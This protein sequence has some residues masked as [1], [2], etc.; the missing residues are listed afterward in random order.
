MM[1]R[2][3]APLLQLLWWKKFPYFLRSFRLTLFS[4][5]FKLLFNDVIDYFLFFYRTWKRTQ[6]QPNQGRLSPC[7]H[8]IKGFSQASQEALK[9]VDCGV[10]LAFSASLSFFNEGVINPMNKKNCRTRCVFYYIYLKVT[11]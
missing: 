7:C 5:N 4:S 2:I 9:K 1:N 6:V 11:T 3:H 8:Q 10:L